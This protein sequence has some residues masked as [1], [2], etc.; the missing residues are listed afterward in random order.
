MC[1][2]GTAKYLVFPADFRARHAQKR[3]R[4]GSPCAVRVRRTGD[5]RPRN[6]ENPGNI[7]NPGNPRNPGDVRDEE[8]EHDEEARH[9]LHM[10]DAFLIRHTHSLNYHISWRHMI[11]NTELRLSSMSITTQIIPEMNYVFLKTR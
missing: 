5:A 2:K 7:R 3:T 4:A 11:L 8:P 9:H 6:P 10:T 1:V